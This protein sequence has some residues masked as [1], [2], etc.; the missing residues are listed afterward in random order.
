MGFSL[1]LVAALLHLFWHQPILIFFTAF[2]PTLVGGIH[3]INQFLRIR[4][5]AEHHGKMAER[6]IVIAN[7][8]ASPDA[9]ND[10]IGRA[11]CRA[12]VCQYVSITV[13]AVSLK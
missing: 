2:V 10:E 5:L 13:A 12:R 6:L 9:V 4:E 3:G 11:S 1:A 7:E 8:L